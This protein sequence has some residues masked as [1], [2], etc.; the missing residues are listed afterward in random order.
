MSRRSVSMSKSP[1]S[2][3]F[4]HCQVQRLTILIT[5]N[6]ICAYL[7]QPNFFK[8]VPMAIRMLEF[9]VLETRI[10]VKEANRTVEQVAILRVVSHGQGEHVQRRQD[11]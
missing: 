3:P 4:M 7:L 5:G 8:V 10:V 11:G 6:Q 2:T 1:V 9:D